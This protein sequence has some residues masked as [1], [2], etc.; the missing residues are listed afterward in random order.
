MDLSDNEQTNANIAS[1]VALYGRIV[2]NCY[3]LPEN[4]F[5]SAIY[6]NYKGGKFNQELA[7]HQVMSL[8][9][10]FRSFAA[11]QL[12]ALYLIGL[13]FEPQHHP[14]SYLLK[15]RGYIFSAC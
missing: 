15:N 5:K 1:L 10:L 2:D 13:L 6:E 4:T 7:P 3:P 9:S 12:D 11:P 14:G 8:L